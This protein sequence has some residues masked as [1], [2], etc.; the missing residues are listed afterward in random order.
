M[1]SSMRNQI[2]FK[3]HLDAQKI[4]TAPRNFGTV[5]RLPPGGNL[6]TPKISALVV[7]KCLDRYVYTL[8]IRSAVPK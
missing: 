7:Y 2:K 6:V 8:K 4:V 1:S 5:P 3:P